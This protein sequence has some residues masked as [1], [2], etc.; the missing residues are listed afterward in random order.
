MG[1]TPICRLYLSM[2][3]FICLCFI[4]LCRVKTKCLYVICPWYCGSCQQ[5]MVMHMAS[6][7]S[8]VW[9]WLDKLSS[10]M[11]QM[12]RPGVSKV[13]C[14]E[15]IMIV[16]RKWGMLLLLSVLKKLF[17]RLNSDCTDYVLPLNVNCVTFFLQIFW[18]MPM[19]PCFSHVDKIHSCLNKL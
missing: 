19:C 11:S 17:W 9:T 14:F 7:C 6:R 8:R 1:F 3:D 2:L 18:V 10:W 16:K 13:R 15:K 12:E 4:L 5:L